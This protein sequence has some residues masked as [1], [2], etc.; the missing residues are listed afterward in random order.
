LILLVIVLGFLVYW[1]LVLLAT[2]GV[3]ECPPEVIT[4]DGHVIGTWM[5]WAFLLQEL[6]ELLLH[7][8][9]LAA[10]GTI[11]IRDENIWLAFSVWTRIVPLAVVVAVVV[12]TPHI[13]ILVPREPHPHLL[14]LF[15]PVVHHITKARN[16]FQPVPPEVSVDALVV[17][18]S[19]MPL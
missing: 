12:W 16:S 3:A 13:A 7:R 2:T 1:L 17:T 4:V 9:L 11:H 18:G 8:Q 5:P 19:V 6:L 15:R 14:L 10:R